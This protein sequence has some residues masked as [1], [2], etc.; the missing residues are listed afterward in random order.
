MSIQLIK[1]VL[2]LMIGVC[3]VT[4]FVLCCFIEPKKKGKIEKKD[5]L[6]KK[7]EKFLKNTKLDYWEWDNIEK[8]LQS[9]GITYR[10]NGNLTPVNFVLLKC[11]SAFGFFVIGCMMQ[12]KI[13]SIVFAVVGFFVVDCLFDYWNKSDNKEMLNDISTM[14]ITF[15]ILDASHVPMESIIDEC[16]KNVETPRLRKALFEFELEIVRDY[17]IETSIDNF[18]GKFNNEYIKK[19]CVA[20]KHSLVTGDSKQLYDDFLKQ[21]DEISKDYDVIYERKLKNKFGVAIFTLFV[22]LMSIV[23]LTMF[24]SLD[25]SLSSLFL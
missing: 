1:M 3:T 22:L 25:K 11:V 18:R 15:R 14:F 10:T 20:M 4:V 19:L 9:K 7:I 2:W 8:M 16:L 12:M 23:G 5:S 6:S 17:N 24:T 13:I 21:V